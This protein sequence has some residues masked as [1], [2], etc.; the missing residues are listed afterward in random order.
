MESDLVAFI[1]ARTLRKTSI[2]GVELSQEIERQ[3]CVPVSRTTINILRRSLRFKYQPPR[4]NQMLTAGHIAD[5]IAFCTKMLAMREV[6]RTIH[7]PNEPCVIL[8]DDR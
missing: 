4:H 3:F 2:S 1:E 7:F 5:C 8:A 6:S